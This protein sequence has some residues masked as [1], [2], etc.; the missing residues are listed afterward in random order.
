MLRI[1]DASSL[2]HGWDSYPIEIFPPLWDWLAQQVASGELQFPD[3]A[4]V[5]INDVCPEA[6][7]WLKDQTVKVVATTPAMLT[8]SMVIK[9]IL[10]VVNDEYNPKGVDENDLLI[11]SSASVNGVECVSDEAKQNDLPINMKKYKIP[12][13]CKHEGV[14]VQCCN[15][16]DYLKSSGVKFA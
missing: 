1:V 3:V 7:Q 12:A 9:Q 5:E 15:F 14:G 4:Y 2:V 6:G 11:I 10:G 13:V 16:L 8:V